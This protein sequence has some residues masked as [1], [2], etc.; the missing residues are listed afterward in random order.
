MTASM[1]ASSLKDGVAS[2]HP[3]PPAPANV[4]VVVTGGDASLPVSIMEDSEGAQTTHLARRH[5]QR[6]RQQRTRR[7]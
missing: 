7:A 2:T 1:M 6:R 3:P 4:A 5:T